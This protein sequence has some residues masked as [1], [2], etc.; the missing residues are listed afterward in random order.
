MS[1]LIL[2]VLVT[3][4][5]AATVWL[6]TTR[7]ERDNDPDSTFWYTFTGLCMLAPMILIP[8]LASNLSSIVL[9]V[10]AAT[11]AIAMH[12]FLRRRRALA[13]TAAHRGQLQAVLASAV[14]QH[15]GIIDLWACYLLD[16]DTAGRYPAMTNIHQPETAALVRAMSASERLTPAD[17]LTDDAVASYQRSVTQLALAWV[18]AEKAAA[19]T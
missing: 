16:P 17:P 3:L 13:L 9:L 18:T 2:A 4:T 6:A 11:S 12:L 7:A 10:L 5:A 14:E 15:Q 1:F 8:A 19:N